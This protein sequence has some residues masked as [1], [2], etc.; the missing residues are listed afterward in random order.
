MVGPGNQDQGCCTCNIEDKAQAVEQC[1]LADGY[2]HGSCDHQD[3][4]ETAGKRLPAEM[5]LKY[6]DEKGQDCQRI[7]QDA[8]TQKETVGD[9]CF[10]EEG[11]GAC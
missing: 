11:S 3:E 8:D 2:H 1:V 7:D 4:G 5:F 9:A 6:G 10:P